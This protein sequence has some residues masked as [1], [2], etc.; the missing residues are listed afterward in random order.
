M[1]FLWA[2]LSRGMQTHTFVNVAFLLLFCRR[3]VKNS[4][5]DQWP[6]VK[7]SLKKSE[8]AQGFT[9]SGRRVVRW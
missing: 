7:N 8:R 9:R 2:L 1:K 6:R 5:R 4:D 3:L